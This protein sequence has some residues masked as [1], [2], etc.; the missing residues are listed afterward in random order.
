VNIVGVPIRVA[1][2]NEPCRQLVRGQLVSLLHRYPGEVPALGLTSGE[3]TGER[4]AKR[5]RKTDRSSH[6]RALLGASQKDI[7]AAFQLDAGDFDL[8]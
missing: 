8:C 7:C 2:I 6:R 4:R 1:G 5:D 3:R